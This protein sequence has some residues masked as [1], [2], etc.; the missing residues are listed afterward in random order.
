MILSDT[1]FGTNSMN[2]RR[3]N[4][5]ALSVLSKLEKGDD[6]TFKFWAIKEI[7]AIFRFHF[8]SDR[9][10]WLKA[11]S[12]PS[13]SDLEEGDFEKIRT[14]LGEVEA[15]LNAIK[16]WFAEEK[17]D[18]PEAITKLNDPSN[19]WEGMLAGY[20]KRIHN[21]EREQR[22]KS[23]EERSDIENEFA[24]TDSVDD[25]TELDASKPNSLETLRKSI[26]EIPN[27]TWKDLKIELMTDS[28][29][30]FK[31]INS[32]I[33]GLRF[34]YTD[35]GMNDKRKTDLPNTMFALLAGF[36]QT[37][38]VFLLENIGFRNRSVIEKTISRLRG[39]LR[40]ITGIVGNPI[41]FN[42]YEGY[43]TQFTA[44]DRRPS[45]LRSDTD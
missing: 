35:L 20:K 21:Y 27:F 7:D 30:R 2:Q 39:K 15:K 41:P 40:E 19:K 34:S 8:H 14:E 29:I 42:Q 22:N 38:G 11:A 5:I 10:F 1:P 33:K 26:S 16:N 44:I 23:E 32:K 13:G 43:K 12:N 6:G 24:Q 9:L 45:R 4:R 28:V 25:S 37:G 17:I 18:L 31:I 36:I 3:W